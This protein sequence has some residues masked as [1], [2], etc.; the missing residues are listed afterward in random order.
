MVE[1]IKPGLF[2]KTV[3]ADNRRMDFDFGNEQ[4]LFLKKDIDVLFI[5][6]S[7]TQL[8]DITAY[9]GMDFFIVNRA[10]GGDDSTY[11]LRRFDADCIQLH[12]KKCILLIGANDITETEY[13][14]WWRKPGK[15]VE[16]VMENYKTNIRQMINKCE[17]S[18]IP[19]CICSIIPSDIAPPYDKAI[20][21]DMTARMNCFLKEISE[22]KL[23]PYIDYHSSLC[24]ADGKTIIPAYTNDG[25]HPN[26]KCYGI[27][28]D[29]L[30][31][32]L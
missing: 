8:W 19:L 1:L 16:E 14:H 25:I 12:P 10:I 30:S 26:A 32:Y 28:S 5:G 9:M 24:Q 29:I 3:H 22:S 20:R 15:S 4:L 23:L 6:D 11:L 27:M 13:D 7:I 21:F 31:E 2:G 18:D 17:E